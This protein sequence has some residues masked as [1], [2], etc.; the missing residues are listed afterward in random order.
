MKSAFFGVAALAALALSTGTASAHPP[1]YY[2]GRPVVV[3][4]PAPVF[5]PPPVFV[6]PQPAFGYNSGSSFSF[7][8]NR[9]GF[10]FGF[11]TF[12]PQPVYRSTFYGYPG[13]NNGFYNYG[14][15]W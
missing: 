14:R 1:S 8:I 9:P 15:R 7:G 3:V 12:D 10:S 11:N 13:F 6:S 5:V 4:R 2:Y